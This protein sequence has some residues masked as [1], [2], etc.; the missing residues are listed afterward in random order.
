MSHS[1]SC[2]W[3]SSIGSHGGAGRNRLDGLLGLTRLGLELLGT[4]LLEAKDRYDFR[5][6]AGRRLP[7]VPPALALIGGDRNAVPT[8]SDYPAHA[9]CS[10]MQVSTRGQFSI[11]YDLMD[12]K[13]LRFE[14]ERRAQT[15]YVP[16]PFPPMP[17]EVD[18]EHPEKGMQGPTLWAA[19]HLAAERA[20]GTKP[21][22][23]I[24]VTQA[25]DPFAAE[26]LARLESW[27]VDQLPNYRDTHDEDTLWQRCLAS[28]VTISTPSLSG[29]LT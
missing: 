26:C 1:S 16:R 29:T 10:S 17:G 19:L 24:S 5:I 18:V 13:S 14:E 4:R 2:V 8:M 7:P 25:V 21:S 23:L 9:R 28:A 6:V 20:D 12:G 3:L 11:Y 22:V 15:P 27:P